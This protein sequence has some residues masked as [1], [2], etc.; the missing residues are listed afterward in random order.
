[1]A[2]ILVA[3]SEGRFAERI[4]DALAADGWQLEVVADA[5]AARRADQARSHDV[6]IVAAE[7]PGAADLIA[8]WADRLIG[9]SLALVAESGGAVAVAARAHERL[10]KPFTDSDLRLAVRRLAASRRA[11]AAA[12]AGERLT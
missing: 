7:L 5:D 11:A 8:R 12:D 6:L 4:R 1:M 10:D 2:W 9:G 3:E